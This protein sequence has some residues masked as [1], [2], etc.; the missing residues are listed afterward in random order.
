MLI[1]R[2]ALTAAGQLLK[3]GQTYNVSIRPCHDVH[4][5]LHHPRG[6]E[7]DVGLLLIDILTLV[8]INSQRPIVSLLVTTKRKYHFVIYD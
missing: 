5:V 2:L 4:G 3:D 7:V 6:D 1:T 8:S